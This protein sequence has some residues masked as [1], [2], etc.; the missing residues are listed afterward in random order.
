MPSSRSKSPAMTKLWLGMIT[1]VPTAV[2]SLFQSCLPRTPSLAMRTMLLDDSGVS[3]EGPMG[4]QDPG[5]LVRI[6]RREVP[7]LGDACAGSVGS[8]ERKGH[9]VVSVGLLGQ[10]EE[11][12]GIGGRQAR[13]RPPRFD[14]RDVDRAGRSC[15]RSSRARGRRNPPRRKKSS[16]PTRVREVGSDPPAP[17]TRSATRTVPSAVPSERQSSSPEMPSL[18]TKYSAPFISTSSRGANEA[19]AGIAKVF[20]RRVPAEVPSDFQSSSRFGDEEKL[21]A[22]AD[23]VVGPPE[24]RPEAVGVQALDEHRAFVRSV[25]APELLRVVGVARAEEKR[26]VQSAG[27]RK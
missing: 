6:V 23:E 5:T 13:R 1:T 3:S 25:A 24:G 15:R 18:A 9:D 12:P 27:T 16:S 19:F 4:T 22:D 20:S 26:R 2:P 7:D 21:S 17:G 14:R 10:K 11:E 8:P